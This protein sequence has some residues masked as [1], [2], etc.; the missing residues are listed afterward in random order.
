MKR[1]QRG[2]FTV[3]P[4]DQLQAVINQ[5]ESQIDF[6]EMAPHL[7]NDGLNPF[8]NVSL[9]DCKDIMDNLQLG[10]KA[11]KH[12]KSKNKINRLRA[13]RFKTLYKKL[14]RQS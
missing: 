5:V 4:V 3:H 2:D 7:R 13:F 10:M 6:Y 1:V 14:L 9:E 11:I 12:Y 8:R